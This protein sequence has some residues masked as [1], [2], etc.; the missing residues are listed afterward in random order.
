MV[1]TAFGSAGAVTAVA[2]ENIETSN[3]DMG[4][5]LTAGAAKDLQVDAEC[6][7]YGGTNAILG[8][9][10]RESAIRGKLDSVDSH[11][12]SLIAVGA[13]AYSVDIL[14][15]HI[16]ATAG[17]AIYMDG[18]T[19]SRIHHPDI[20]SP[21][22]HGIHLIDCTWIRVTDPTIRYPGFGSLATYDGIYLEGDCTDVFMDGHDIVPEPANGNRYG[23]N[24]SAA[25]CLRTIIGAG[26]PRGNTAPVNDAGTDTRLSPQADEWDLPV[27][28]SRTDGDL[29]KWDL[30]TGTWVLAAGGA[31]SDSTAIH[32]DTAGEINAIASKA[33]AVAADVLV[34]EDSAA[35]FV[36]KKVLRS[37]LYPFKDDPA[38][39]TFLGIGAGA[40]NTIADSTGFGYQSLAANT[41]GYHNSAFGRNALT[42]MVTSYQNSAFGFYSLYFATSSR[43]SAFGAS[44]YQ[45]LTSG[46]RNV[47]IGARAGYA[48]AGITANASTTAIA[49]TLVGFET[50]QASATQR[51]EVVAVGFQALVDADYATALGSSAQALHANAVALGKGIV[52]TAASQ[53]AIGATHIEMTEMTAPG[54][55]AANQGRVYL[56]TATGDYMI[57]FDS[58]NTAIL[59]A[60]V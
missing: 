15:V 13:N 19:R 38:G 21:A 46:N 41:T 53:V 30:A 1:W 12:V 26:N 14:D 50:G 52:T 57:K 32:D 8:G 9:D 23:I 59:A 17:S 11:T 18:Y 22:L 33:A 56:D 29:V 51:S 20:D 49:Q 45:N 35:A 47:A 60:Y 5:D 39:A 6:T 44:A 36:K 10:V 31:G 27:A 4:I 42:S 2:F 55:P 16:A 40:V 43:N 3:C 34:I 24:I 58:G 37:G 54:T 25:G 7:I 28:G 48:P